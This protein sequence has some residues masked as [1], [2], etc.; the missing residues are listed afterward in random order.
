MN[1]GAAYDHDLEYDGAEPYGGSVGGFSSEE[2]YEQGGRQDAGQGQG[3]WAVGQAED[4]RAL[5]DL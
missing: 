1:R 2:G 4:A 3:D 5:E